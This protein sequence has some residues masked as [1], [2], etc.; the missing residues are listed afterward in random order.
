MDTKL[1]F[2]IHFNSPI[3]YYHQIAENIRSLITKGQLKPGDMLPPEKT[4]ASQLGVSLITVRHA[5]KDLTNEGLLVRRRAVGTF[6]APP[7]Q[8]FPIMR[9][10]LRG[11]TEEMA[12][13][14]LQVRSSVLEHGLIS[15]GGEPAKELQL[16]YDEKVIRIRRLRS[17][18]D[19]PLVIEIT[20]HPYARFP[21][22]L[23][24]DF[25]DK[26]IYAVFEELYNTRPVESKDYFVAD[27]ATKDIAELLD[28]DVG[29]PIM[30]YK[31][32]AKDKSGQVMEFTVSIYRADLYQ[33]VI[34]YQSDQ[35]D[36]PQG[37]ET[38]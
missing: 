28:I 17:V 29:A 1:P 32:T 8:I 11:L 33:F 31:R 3:P 27:I 22:L 13:E 34:Y 9:P 4:I 5:L 37:G 21:K 23:D 19:V 12:E 24:I 10:R 30:R 38:S 2:S 18:K 16:P 35:Q 36:S 25:T 14:G 6:V 7:R 20:H 26:S 15:A